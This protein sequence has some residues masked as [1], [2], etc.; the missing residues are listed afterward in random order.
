MEGI[1]FKDNTFHSIVLTE[2]DLAEMIFDKDEINDN[3]QK[4]FKK[5]NS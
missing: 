2:S 1:T 5:N 3:K 4:K